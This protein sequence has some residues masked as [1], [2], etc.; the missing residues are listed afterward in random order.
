MAS[1]EFEDALTSVGFRWPKAA[2][3]TIIE[4]Y[5]TGFDQKVILNVTSDANDEISAHIGVEGNE[6][7]VKPQAGQDTDATVMMGQQVGCRHASF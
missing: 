3:I 2:E 4:L 6:L 1:N 5:A 7:T